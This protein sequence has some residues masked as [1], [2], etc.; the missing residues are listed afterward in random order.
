MVANIYRVI[1]LSAPSAT[2]LI[3]SCA[4]ILSRDSESTLSLLCF[5]RQFVKANIHFEA[6]PHYA[7][8]L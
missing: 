2:F 4:S 7:I 1:I 8:L 5:D 3:Q 6:K